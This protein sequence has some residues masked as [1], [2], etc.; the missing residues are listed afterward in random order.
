M[1]GVVGWGSSI[2]SYIALGWLFD[3]LT[4]LVGIVVLVGATYRGLVADR[5]KKATVA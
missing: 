4:V 3:V 1:A 5:A 2:G